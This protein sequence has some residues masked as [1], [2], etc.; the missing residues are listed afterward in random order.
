M[1]KSEFNRVD[2]G[3]IVILPIIVLIDKYIDKQAI[4]MLEAKKYNELTTLISSMQVINFVYML[5]LF[6][7]LVYVVSYKKK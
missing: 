7:V 6:V 3:L 2:I 4:L 1:K 5:Y